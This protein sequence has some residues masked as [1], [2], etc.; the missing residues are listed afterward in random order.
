MGKFSSRV[1]A[2]ELSAIKRMTMLGKEHPDPIYLSWGRP[3]DDTPRVIKQFTQENLE[4]NGD[5]G[6]YTLPHG[7]D[8]LREVISE[9]HLEKRG[10]NVDPGKNIIVTAGAMEAMFIIMQTLLDPGDE[11]IMPSPGFASYCHHVRIAGGEPKF[12]P[13]NEDKDWDMTDIEPLITRKTKAIVVTSPNNPTGSVFSKETIERVVALARKHGLYVISD[14]IYDHLIYD[15]AEYYVPSMMLDQYDRIISVYSLSKRYHMTGWRVGYIVATD[16][17]IDNLIKVHDAATIC[18]SSVSQCGAIAAI[19]NDGSI[20]PGVKS[21]M[22]IHR[23][24]ICQELDTLP[25]VFEYV[26]PQGAYY[27]FPRIVADYGNDTE[28]FAKKLIKETGVVTVPGDAFGPDGE[29]HLRM[30]FCIG[31]DRIREGF[32]RLREYFG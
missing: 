27:I 24:L 13:L 4:D 28:G 1:S 10:Q 12:L 30:A 16:D 2:I 6:K 5:V 31:N 29:G 17:V 18:A 25:E 9:Y 19:K 32:R 20:V 7:S 14:E 15:D 21:K 11:V 23:E 22:E 8:D 3:E 26:K